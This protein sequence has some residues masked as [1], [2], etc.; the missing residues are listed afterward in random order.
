MKSFERLEMNKV[1]VKK[2]RTE[3][4]GRGV[5]EVGF[6]LDWSSPNRL[7]KVREWRDERAVCVGS[8]LEQTSRLMAYPFIKGDISWETKSLILKHASE[9]SPLIDSLII[10]E[11]LQTEFRS[12][13]V[14]S[15]ITPCD[16]KYFPL[17]L[18]SVL[19]S[20]NGFPIWGEKK[21]I[22]LKSLSISKL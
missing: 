1:K 8:P 2:L 6:G 16:H 3:N 10:W 20:N 14:D 5:E 22:I 17:E 13:N 4:C 15:D 19:N 9:I 12:S 18:K 7:V 21:Q 11:M